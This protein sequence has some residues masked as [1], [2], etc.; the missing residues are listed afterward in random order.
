M[1]LQTLWILFS[2]SL[3]IVPCA[4]LEKSN[5]RAEI[6]LIKFDEFNMASCVQ[7]YLTVAPDNCLF[8]PNGMLLLSVNLLV[9]SMGFV[10]LLQ[11][12]S[13]LPFFFVCSTGVDENY[14]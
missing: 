2:L 7:R 4:I 14:L 8:P 5:G 12:I 3:D 6:G 9:N 1:T 13:F 10:N 11:R